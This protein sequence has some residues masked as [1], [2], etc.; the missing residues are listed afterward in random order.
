MKRFKDN[1]DKKMKSLPPNSPTKGKKIVVL[2]MHSKT[3][4]RK[5]NFKK[6]KGP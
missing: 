1:A 4:E 2:F 3:D 6:G 5:R